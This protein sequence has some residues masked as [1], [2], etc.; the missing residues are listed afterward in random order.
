MTF[1]D[2]ISTCFSNYATFRGTASRSEYWW[3]SLF[4]FLVAAVLQNLNAPAYWAF[5][6]ATTI[7][8]LSV[9]CRRLHDTDRSG[10]WQLLWLVPVIGWIV[11]IIFFV[12][13]SRDSTFSPHESGLRKEPGSY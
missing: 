10:W 6:I 8:S 13:V 11:L 5:F 3:F 12:Q 1:T 4:T 2:S 9:G 7:P